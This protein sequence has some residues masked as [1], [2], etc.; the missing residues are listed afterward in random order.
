[1]DMGTENGVNHHLE[2]GRRVREPKEHDEGF[3]EALGREESRFPLVSFFDPNI[4]V[5]PSHIELREQ[6]TTR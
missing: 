5:P 6:G 4:V 2:G 3:K 1:M